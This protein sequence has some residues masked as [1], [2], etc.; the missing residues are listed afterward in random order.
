MRAV[1]LTDLLHGVEVLDVSPIVSETVVSGV[2]QDSRLV[3]PRW[4]FCCRRG[5]ETDGHDHAAEALRRGAAAMLVERMLPHP[6]PQ[7]MVRD[8]GTAIGQAA[9]SFWG[10]PSDQ[11]HLIGVTGTNGKTTTTYLVR[12]ILEH[13]GWPTAAIGTLSG[14]LT[15]P[16]PPELHRRLAELVTRG[17]LAAAMEVSSHGLVQH[18]VEATRFLVGVFTN[19]DR[20]HLDYHDD[21]E[22]YFEAKA[23]LFAPARV[24]VGV[25][26]RDDPWGSRLLVGRRAPIVSYSLDDATN[27]DRTAEGSSFRWRGQQIRLPIPGLFNVYN[28]LAAATTAACLDVPESTIAESLSSASAPPGR[29]EQIDVGQPFHI[30]VDCAHTPSALQQVLQ[31]LRND[32]QGRL[33]VVFGCG[34]DRDRTKRPQMGTT[35]ANHADLAIL[36]ADNP[37]TE[38]LPQILADVLSA[39]AAGR[40][41]VE[42]DR[43]AAIAAAIGMAEPNDTV[44]I[45][46]KGDQTV[47]QIG[48]AA[49]PFD[50][51]QVAREVVR[52]LWARRVHRSSSLRIS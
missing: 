8:T 34:G 2:T 40:I 45:A 33:I 9:A 6:V 43:R 51:R 31:S 39:V 4:L 41:V 25:V 22:S 20:D 42:P 7:V 12:A 27:L 49:L 29:M 36:T 50:D 47:Q 37:R 1:H 13:H 38:P 17:Y 5:R 11:L 24:E 15:T 23:S 26:N 16:D 35:V 52:S 30:V 19:L 10:N 44:L 32:C 21:M 14:P 48:E 28:A 18:R 46:G 3:E